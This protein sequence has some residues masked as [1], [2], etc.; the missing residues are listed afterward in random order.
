MAVNNYRSITEFFTRTGWNQN[1]NFRIVFGL[2]YWF[3]KSEVRHAFHAAILKYHPDRN[4]VLDT[5][6]TYTKIARFLIRKFKQAEQ[7]LAD[8]PQVSD[9]EED[10]HSEDG[11]EANQIVA[12][13]ANHPV[14]MIDLTV[15]NDYEVGV[16]APLIQPH[17]ANV[18][19]D[20]TEDE[21][22][23]VQIIDLTE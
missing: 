16:I 5:E 19:I 4:R 2:D 3:T 20:L 11:V 22:V 10:A 15:D 12:M 18:T 23:G 13:V 21:A 7:Y 9:E 14:E 8:E 6:R 17:N 1:T